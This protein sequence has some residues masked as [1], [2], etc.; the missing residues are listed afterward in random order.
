MDRIRSSIPV[1]ALR[2]YVRAFAQRH[3]N[4]T[5]AVLQPVTASLE[6]VLQFDFGDP[7]FIDYH[8]GRSES[9][10][11]VAVVGAHSSHRASIR[12]CGQIESFAVFFQPFGLWQLF[13]LPNSE[14]RDQAYAEV[15]ILGGAVRQLWLQMAEAPSFEKRVEI[16]ESFLVRRAST[17]AQRTPS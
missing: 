16:V 1:V 7:L 4:A 8:D 3:V 12:F 13:G 14:L 2:P 6:Q 9:S 10:G 17:A 15:E 11:L 5:S